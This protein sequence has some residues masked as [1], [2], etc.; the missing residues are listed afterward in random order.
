[1]HVGWAKYY[2]SVI[3]GEDILF[4]MIYDDHASNKIDYQFYMEQLLKPENSVAK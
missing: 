2:I 1:M 4:Y 3:V